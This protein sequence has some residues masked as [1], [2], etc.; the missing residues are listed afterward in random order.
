[1]AR[2]L[3]SH[4]LLVCEGVCTLAHILIYRH[5]RIGNFVGTKRV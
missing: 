5:A 3:F 1:M 4:E 2:K